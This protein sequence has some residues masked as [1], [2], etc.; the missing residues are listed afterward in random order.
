MRIFIVFLTVCCVFVCADFKLM[1]KPEK[2]V[3]K[4]DETI[5]LNISYEEE[6][7]NQVWDTYL[8]FMDQTKIARY[9]I[10]DGNNS[11]EAKPLGML[12]KTI[13]LKPKY[14]LGT[15]NLRLFLCLCKEGTQK[16]FATATARL[17]IIGKPH[18]H[19]HEEALG[20]FPSNHPLPVA[21][22]LLLVQEIAAEGECEARGYT[23]YKQ[24]DSRWK[25]E[26][27]SAGPYTIG[28][29]GC[30]MSC[31]ANI[32]NWTPS[33]LNQTLKSNGGYSGNLIIWGKVPGIS[34]VRFDSIR[35]SLF[36]E[37]HVIAN[38]GG[39]FVLLTGIKSSGNYYSHDPGRSSNPVYSTSQIQSVVLYRK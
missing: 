2:P 24:F 26:I 22:Q 13:E 38:L 11:L 23:D 10:I 37:F 1:I 18:G 32:I 3:Y 28:Q 16:I 4:A 21:P 17:T 14:W 25:N 31:A 9:I 6:E 35:D 7:V 33:A 39:H 36:N 5:V 15:S 29:I 8:F 30:A 19:S 12:P 34:F 27:L 20:D